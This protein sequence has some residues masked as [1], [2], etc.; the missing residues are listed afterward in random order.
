MKY[1]IKESQVKNLMWKYFDSPDYNVKKTPHYLFLENNHDNRAWVYKIYNNKLLVSN[2]IIFGFAAMFNVSG[3]DA[4]EYAGE[5]F[6][7][8]YD[9]PVNEIVNWDFSD[10]D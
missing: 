1:I 5:W 7:E 6:E 8:K 10:N 9:Y 3:E 2:D 4:L